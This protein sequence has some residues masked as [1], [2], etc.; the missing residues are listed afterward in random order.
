MMSMIQKISSLLLLFVFA[1]GTVAIAQQSQDVLSA[2]SYAGD[3]LEVEWSP[4]AIPSGEKVSISINMSTEN[5][6][7]TEF[8]DALGEK[9]FEF[10]AT[11]PEGASKLHV[12]TD[13]FEPGVYVVRV[14]TDNS[15]STEQVIIQ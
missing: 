6:M 9:V 10:S 13:S 7:H 2:N 14:S 8:R 5:E 12:H 1:L 3:D 15:T 11:Y 4:T